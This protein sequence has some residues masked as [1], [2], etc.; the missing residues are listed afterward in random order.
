M[1]SRLPQN[2]KNPNHRLAHAAF[3][4]PSVMSRGTYMQ[5]GASEGSLPVARTVTCVPYCM[6]DCVPA[7]PPVSF[8]RPSQVKLKNQETSHQTTIR[9]PIECAPEASRGGLQDLKRLDLTLP[10]AQQ[11]EFLRSPCLASCSTPQQQPSRRRARCAHT[12]QRAAAP[13][14]SCAAAL[15][16]SPSVLSTLHHSLQ[17]RLPPSRSRQGPSLRS[18]TLL[19]KLFPRQKMAPIPSAPS[20]VLLLGSCTSGPRCTF[21]SGLSQNCCPT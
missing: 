11:I 17:I 10:E 12:A 3:P 5:L 13:C 14:C 7:P 9:K 18:R 8:C 6:C 15:H 1:P 19:G 21:G 4:V 20:R 16:C 2:R